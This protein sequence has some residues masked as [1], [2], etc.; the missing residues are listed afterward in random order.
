MNDVCREAHGDMFPDDWRY[1]IIRD[2]VDWIAENGAGEDDPAEFADSTTEVYT[3]KLADWLGSHSDRV[4]YCDEAAQEFGS[5]DSMFETMQ[6]GQ[7]MER[8]EVFHYV[9]EALE[10]IA[11]E[12]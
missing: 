3:A 11:D 8:E 10:K 6:R 2:A 4:G 9:V 1:S 5:S 12:D 7:Y